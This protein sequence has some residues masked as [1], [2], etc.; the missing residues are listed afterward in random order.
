MIKGQYNILGLQITDCEANHL[1]AEIK[2]HIKNKK[3]LLIAALPIN[4]IIIAYL[5][6][7]FKYVLN[8]FNYLIPDSVWVKWSINL[9][10]NTKIKDR[11]RGTNLTLEICKLAQD[12]GYKVFLYG[13]TKSTLLNLKKNLEKQFPLIKIVGSLSPPF[14]DLNM[15]DK[16]ELIDKLIKYKVNILFIALGT[17]K[18]EIFG[19]D[20]VYNEPRY[21]KPII[22][23]PVGAVF[24][25]ISGNKKQAPKWMQE[26]GLE[27]LFRLIQEPRRLWKRYLIYGPLF[28]YLI[29]IQKISSTLHSFFKK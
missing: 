21:S 17:P 12:K 25:F 3:N 14:R 23:V 1:L 19:Y 27:W 24:D 28:I 15:K 11:I 22:I 16:T 13:S 8:K 29:F 6:S 2:S 5:D 4:Q 9:L 26:T 7:K 18:Q 20:L 10:Y